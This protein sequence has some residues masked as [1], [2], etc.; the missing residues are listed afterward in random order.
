MWTCLSISAVFGI[1]LVCAR[2]WTRHCRRQYR[3]ALETQVNQAFEELRHA[4]QTSNNIA[5]HKRL[6]A[7]WLQLLAELNDL[8]AD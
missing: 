2:V 5:E 4:T 1:A 7:R 3:E 8:R 6:R